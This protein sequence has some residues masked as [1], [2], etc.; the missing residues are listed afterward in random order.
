MNAE[1]QFLLLLEVKIDAI[2]LLVVVERVRPSYAVNHCR[3]EGGGSSSRTVPCFP[4][5]KRRALILA[6]CCFSSSA[7]PACV[8]CSFFS[9]FCAFTKIPER[10]NIYDSSIF[11]KTLRKTYENDCVNP[12][13]NGLRDFDAANGIVFW[14]FGD[15]YDV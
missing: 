1:A 8:V 9:P 12:I 13:L 15:Q 4:K 6:A 5:I 14:S 3:W 11:R 2:V 7:L 10:W